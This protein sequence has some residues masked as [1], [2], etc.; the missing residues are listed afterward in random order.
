MGVYGVLFFLLFLYFFQLF[1]HYPQLKGN[2]KRHKNTNK[3]S[4]KIPLDKIKKPKE[5]SNV[6]LL[7]WTA[8]EMTIKIIYAGSTLEESRFIPE[9]FTRNGLMPFYKLLKFL[10]LM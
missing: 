5:S 3:S 4:C 8:I 6:M 2:S 1:I 10:S 7:I 9:Y